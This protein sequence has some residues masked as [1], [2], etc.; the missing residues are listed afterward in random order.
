[1]PLIIAATYG[2]GDPNRQGF[3]DEA[4]SRQNDV[5]R[6]GIAARLASL[7]PMATEAERR[8]GGGQIRSV[9]LRNPHDE[10]ARVTFVRAH[11]T[12]TSNGDQITFDGTNGALVEASVAERSAPINDSMLSLHE[13]LFAGAVLRWLYFL[14]GL[15]GTVMIGTGL[16]LWTAKR[17]KQGTVPHLGLAVVERLNVGTIAGLPVSTAAYFWANRLM[18]ADLAARG[19]WE[20]HALF[21]AW[22]AMLAYPLLRPVRR[23]WI[24][25]FSLAAAL[26]GSLPIVNALTTERHLGATLPARDWVLAGFDLTMLAFGIGFAAVAWRLQRQTALTAPRVVRRSTGADP[27]ADPG[28]ETA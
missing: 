23:A 28:P 9:D 14:S 12:P 2:A 24:E 8:W 19:E 1:M 18:P 20:V 5:E 6:A 13:G 21:I 16:V 4:F 11:V 17:R 15:L 3:F 22:T 26:Y 7:E 27:S 10:N 25:E